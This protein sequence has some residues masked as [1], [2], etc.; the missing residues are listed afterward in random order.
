[1]TNSTDSL[2]TVL[3]QIFSSQGTQIVQAILRGSSS[4]AGVFA[5]TVL[6][7]F[8]PFLASTALHAQEAG[9]SAHLASVNINNADAETLAAGLRGIGL[10]RAQEIVRYR[11]AFGPFASVDELT[12]VKGVGASTLENNRAVITLE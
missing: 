8:N 11:E 5:L 6:L 12:E 4:L 9:Q 7:G 1:M 2:Q 10:S 3:P